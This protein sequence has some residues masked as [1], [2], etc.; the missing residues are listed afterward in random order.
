MKTY[1]KFPTLQDNRRPLK[2]IGVV[3][4]VF[5][6]VGNHRMYAATT[7]NPEELEGDIPNMNVGRALIIIVLVHLV[8]I[9]GFFLRK[10]IANAEAERHAAQAP[11]R[12]ESTV[13][14][15]AAAQSPNTNSITSVQDLPPI[16]HGDRQHMVTSEDT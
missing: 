1:E 6:K 10:K 13:A 5:A 3:R 4:R 11:A 8:C 7:A 2:K 12:Q 14:S 16:Q 9:G 15:T